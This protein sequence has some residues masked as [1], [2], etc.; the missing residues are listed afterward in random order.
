MLC[1]ELIFGTYIALF[2]HILF[3]TF[4]QILL[5]HTDGEQRSRTEHYNTSFKVSSEV[6]YFLNK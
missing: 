3:H 5:L 1:E 4:Q 2:T 6:R